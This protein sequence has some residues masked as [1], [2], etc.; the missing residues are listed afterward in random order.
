MNGQVTSYNYN[1]LPGF[2]H[3]Q[4]QKQQTKNVKQTKTFAEVHNQ[5]AL[6][7]FNIINVM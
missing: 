5:I 1:I 6:H 7:E 2:V 3:D 4:Q